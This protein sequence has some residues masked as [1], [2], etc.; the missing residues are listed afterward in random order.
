LRKL[1]KEADMRLRSIKGTDRYFVTDT[2]E[3]YNNETGLPDL[4]PGKNGGIEGEAFGEYDYPALLAT[5][6]NPGT[7][8]ITGSLVRASGKRISSS[9]T[10]TVS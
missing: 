3:V 6:A 10:I 1:N 9:T 7:Y 4:E 2:G 5:F 8:E